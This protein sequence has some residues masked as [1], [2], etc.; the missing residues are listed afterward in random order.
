MRKWISFVFLSLFLLCGCNADTALPS[1]VSETVSLPA[2]QT[3]SAPESTVSSE[4][5]TG[6]GSSALTP[7]SSIPKPEGAP[8]HWGLSTLNIAGMQL[9]KGSD[10][11][12][13]MDVGLLYL[14]DDTIVFVSSHRM[15]FGNLLSNQPKNTVSIYE[16]KKSTN[17][18]RCVYKRQIGIETGN[19]IA[20]WL[21]ISRLDAKSILATDK[22]GFIF[23]LSLPD[24]KRIDEEKYDKNG[25]TAVS[26]ED[27]DAEG[28]LIV[29][30]DF[31]SWSADQAENL[32]V[33]DKVL[34]NS[35]GFVNDKH[36]VIATTEDFN[37]FKNAKA[38]PKIVFQ[39]ADGKSPVEVPI[40]ENVDTSLVDNYD[41]YNVFYAKNKPYV[42]GVVDK[43]YKNP[44]NLPEGISAHLYWIEKALLICNYETG[45]YGFTPCVN[46]LSDIVDCKFNTDE[47][48]CTILTGEFDQFEVRPDSMRNLK[49]YTYAY[50]IDINK[51]IGMN[52]NGGFAK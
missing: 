11:Q 2:A 32:K 40:E 49:F 3:S 42:I 25:L 50:V 35:P 15:Y 48:E 10:Q 6:I 5:M 22:N 26:D 9:I 21:G 16:Y 14:D 52:K 8:R 39:F 51:Y 20:G 23:K 18:L 24:Y 28:R 29:D 36:S 37:H 12:F 34:V 38:N 4:P 1:S 27:I 30:A 43:R 33:G 47:G 46:G 41:F 44:E 17:T 45:E 19:D 13:G 7:I 31:I